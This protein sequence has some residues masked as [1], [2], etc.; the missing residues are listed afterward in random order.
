LA[1]SA[2]EL[3]RRITQPPP[4]EAGASIYLDE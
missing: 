2:N 3:R 1:T 4:I